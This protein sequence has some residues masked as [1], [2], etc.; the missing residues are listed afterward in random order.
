MS[1]V[2]INDERR[3]NDYTSARLRFTAPADYSVQSQC[4]H[5]NDAAVVADCCRSY[6]DAASC[7]SSRSPAAG[8]VT[9]ACRSALDTAESPKTPADTGGP[10]R[11]Y[12]RHQHLQQ[13]QQTASFAIHQLLGLDVT[14]ERQ[15]ALQ[16]AD[17]RHRLQSPATPCNCADCAQSFNHAVDASLSPGAP[18]CLGPRGPYHVDLPYHDR[19][20]SAYYRQHHASTTVSATSWPHLQETF[21]MPSSLTPWSKG[22]AFLPKKT[23]DHHHAPQQQQVLEQ[24]AHDDDLQAYYCAARLQPST[25]EVTSYDSFIRQCR[26]I[27]YLP[28]NFGVYTRTD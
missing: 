25:V 15:L 2:V 16:T 24:R 10:P 19:S 18:D 21:Q 28:P 14:Y 12:Q 1:S 17:G 4:H 22:E 5:V 13:H 9:C 26:N 23:V 11:Y 20:T 3:F 6:S 8:Y 27:S 7:D